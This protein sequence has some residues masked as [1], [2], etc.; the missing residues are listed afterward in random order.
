[1]RRFLGAVDDKNESGRALVAA[2]LAERDAVLG[3]MKDY[4][5][6]RRASMAATMDTTGMCKTAVDMDLRKRGGVLGKEEWEECM[7]LVERV[8]S[9]IQQMARM[10][11]ADCRLLTEL[12][13][14]LR[15]RGGT[16]E[17][18]SMAG[19]VTTRRDMGIEMD[20]WDWKSE[21]GDFDE[22]EDGDE[23][24]EAVDDED[25]EAP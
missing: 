21:D 13:K 5:A 7:E 8:E 10:S 2:E 6:E 1:M 19:D 23:L 18:F 11:T 20:K 16:G 14:Q 3:E 9:K 22:F 17:I 24:W 25:E 12:A 4:M 15:G